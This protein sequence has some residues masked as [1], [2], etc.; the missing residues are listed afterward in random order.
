MGRKSV[1]VTV[2]D[3]GTTEEGDK[4]PM[5]H[6][7]RLYYH[8][9]TAELLVRMAEIPGVMRKEL[10]TAQEDEEEDTTTH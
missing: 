7:V 6:V 8:G 3:I 10:L 9:D 5:T 4:F 1:I 2:A